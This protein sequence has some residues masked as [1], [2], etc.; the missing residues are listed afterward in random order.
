MIKK[1]S[2]F[3]AAAAVAITSFILMHPSRA[4]AACGSIPYVFVNNVSIVDAN[5]MNANFAF[6]LGCAT[7]VDNSQIG[8]AGI[9]A[10]QI[11]PS[12]TVTATFGGA[13]GYTIALSSGTQVPLKIV[14]NGAQSTDLFQVFNNSQSTKYVWIDSAGVLHTNQPIATSLTANR[15][16]ITD[17]SGNLAVAADLPVLLSGAQTIAGVK[18]FSSAPVMSGASIS[19]ATIPNAALVNSTIS[20]VALGSN[21][22]ALFGGAHITSATYNGT[23][24]VT[25]TTDATSS[26]TASTIVARDGSGN[27]AMG[28]LTAN[29]SV[30]A[31]NAYNFSSGVLGT[32][33]GTTTGNVIFG[34]S[35]TNFG[36]LYFDGTA[37]RARIGSADTG[38]FIAGSSTYGPTSATINGSLTLNNSGGLLLPNGTS[39]YIQLTDG[40]ATPNKYIRAAGGFLQVMNSA[41]NTAVFSVSDTGAVGA[42][43]AF[44]TGSSTYGPTSATVNGVIT[45]QGGVVTT[46]SPTG[47]FNSE[48]RFT[49]T[50][51]SG[52]YSL[53]T[54]DTGSPTM[55]FDHLGAS[56][57]GS[58]AWRNGTNATS[59]RMTLSSAGLLTATT[60]SG[61]A[62]SL[63]SIPANQFAASSFTSGNCIR[64]TSATALGSAAGDCVTSV[65]ASGNLS[66]SGGT[67]PA[68]T[69]TGSPTFSGLMTSVGVNAG[70]GTVQ[71]SSNG[72]AVAYHPPVYST[73]GASIGSTTHVVQGTASFNSQTGLTVT[74]TGA[75]VFASAT[76]AACFG[77]AVTGG[78]AIVSLTAGNTVAINTNS[79]GGGGLTFTGTV[80]FACIGN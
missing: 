4:E 40:S 31:G 17:G 70:T 41:F 29:G 7:S 21:L 38:V 76:S 18:T 24:N 19:N 59:T 32:A 51:G 48:F 20:G 74:L 57:T 77:S 43:G 14:A 79:S 63:T 61:S 37:F 30:V 58:W 22:F 47:L 56:N 3:L 27:F 28:T 34:T 36:N 5:T 65:T 42:V 1:L 55:Y 12:S 45:A 64:A 44:S 46:G 26:N 25:L 53:N 72:S 6:L 71:G 39:Q 80:P 11:I 78:Y 15:A 62:A 9:Y 2:S 73:S 66:S 16:V 75:A 33:T 35:T 8:P 23:A 52:N 69:M 60:F 13:Y 54:A 67:T 49:N 50:V 10:S 68:I